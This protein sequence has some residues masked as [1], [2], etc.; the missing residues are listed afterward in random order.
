MRRAGLGRDYV[1]GHSLGAQGYLLRPNP[2]LVSG[3]SAK[4]IY[5]LPP[6]LV[7]CLKGLGIM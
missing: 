1:W 7:N 6:E 4:E 3:V 5:K 2:Q